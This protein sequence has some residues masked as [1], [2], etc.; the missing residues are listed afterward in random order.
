MAVAAA[1]GGSNSIGA[2]SQTPAAA[3]AVQ[4]LTRG[5]VSVSGASSHGSSWGSQIQQPCRNQLHRLTDG[6]TQTAARSIHTS[7]AAAA[8]DFYDVL[9]VAKGATDQEIKK[10]YYKLAKKYHP[11]TNK[12]NPEAAKQFQEVSKAYETLRDPEKRRMYDRLGREGMDR[13]EQE[14]GGG[15]GFD[16]GF[17]W[18]WQ[19]GQGGGPAWSVEE[20]MQH[21]F[22]GAAGGAAGGFG[23][24]NMFASA[25]FM[26]D[27][28]LRLTFMEAC[29]GVRKPIDLSRLT[30]M[31]MP[32]VEVDIPPGLNTGQ[33][34]QVK[35]QVP[36][37]QQAINIMLAIEVEPHPQ[38]SRRGHDIIYPLTLRLSE[39][40]TGKTVQVPTIDG[41]SEL[42]VPPLTLSGEV[43][44]MAGK[45]VEHPRTGQRGSQLVTVRVVKPRKLTP[46]Q[47]QLLKEFAAE[48]KD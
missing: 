44:R 27:T 3:A 36:G 17:Q 8:Q 23:G 20:I 39:A 1:E 31:Q 22:G 47:E 13:M 41:R 9:G 16:G 28:P 32:P 33:T 19:E 2:C 6:F 38:F 37:K 26:L 7:T 10:A 5:L 11:D 30:G 40:L 4:Q 45:G 18:Q 42:V 15:G 43:L 48:D 24:G 12:G 14:G 29:K 21:F 25:A 35:A 46:K 34:I